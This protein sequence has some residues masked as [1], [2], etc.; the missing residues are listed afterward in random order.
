[1]TITRDA[2][3]AS[4]K[5]S[6]LMWPNGI[7]CQSSP[8]MAKDN[9]VQ[10]LSVLSVDTPGECLGTGVS[11]TVTESVSV[12]VGKMLSHYHKLGESV[13]F[14]FYASINNIS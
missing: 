14:I 6:G 8:S 1:M 5:H 3:I 2:I 4:S 9:N 7:S 13:C 12:N 11:L 10:R